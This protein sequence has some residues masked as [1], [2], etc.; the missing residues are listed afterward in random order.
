MVSV[1]AINRASSIY[2]FKIVNRNINVKRLHVLVAP[3]AIPLNLIEV[4]FTLADQHAQVTKMTRSSTCTFL[5]IGLMPR[6]HQ[7][8]KN[9][10]ETD[11]PTLVL[12]VRGPS[13]LNALEFIARHAQENFRGIEIFSLLDEIGYL[14]NMLIIGLPL[15]FRINLRIL[16]QILQWRK[17]T[18][19]NV[20]VK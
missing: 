3:L 15:I 11:D 8:F 12:S 5:W 10:I 7:V 17:T 9:I 1:Y 2:T 13:C 14:Q 19:T 4:V 6:Q 16:G 18:N 20:I